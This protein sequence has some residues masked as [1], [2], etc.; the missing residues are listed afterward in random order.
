MS[1]RDA[2]ILLAQGGTRPAA[3]AERL[4]VPPNSVHKWLSDARKQGIDIPRFKRGGARK[5]AVVTLPVQIVEALRPEANAR[6][7]SVREL[8]LA[9]LREVATSDLAAALLDDPAWTAGQLREADHG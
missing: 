4:Q 1:K 9:I 8:A 6:G 3:I 7:T 5:R 2:V